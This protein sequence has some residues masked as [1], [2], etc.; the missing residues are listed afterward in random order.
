MPALLAAFAS[1]DGPFWGWAVLHLAFL[2]LALYPLFALRAYIKAGG[3]VSIYSRLVPPEG[4]VRR[5]RDRNE[6][7]VLFLSGVGRVSSQTHSLREKGILQRLADL[8]PKAVVLDDVF[9]YS[10]NNKPLTEHRRLSLI[11]RWAMRQKLKKRR[12]NGLLGYLI[13]V[14]NIVQVATSSDV[15]YARVYNRGFSRV[16]AHHLAQYGY[17]FNRP[18]PL[19]IVAYSGAG[20]IAA[21]AVKYLREEYDV[22]VYIMML[23]CFFTEGPGI[24]AANHIWEFIGTM[25][26]AYALFYALT[27]SRWVRFGRTAWSRRVKQGGITRISMGA[28]KHTG[29]GGYLDR[30]SLLP[31]GVHYIDHTAQNFADII[32]RICAQHAKGQTA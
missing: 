4:N 25:D 31:N 16:L 26:K 12:L 13:N 22:P 14:R 27:P 9:A 18:Q 21:G 10:I 6:A 17:D 2:W 1:L 24:V 20:Q 5:R 23:A 30:N 7:Y 28:M 32:N 29:R 3:N 15:R 19:F 8:C 11:W